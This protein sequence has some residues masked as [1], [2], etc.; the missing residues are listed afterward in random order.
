MF[1]S[2]INSWE[3]KELIETDIFVFNL[4]NKLSKVATIP[5]GVPR[6]DRLKKKYQK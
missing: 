4:V 3:V 1:H 6:V 2:Y 5:L